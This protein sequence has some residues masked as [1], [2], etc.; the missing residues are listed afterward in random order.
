VAVD[1]RSHGRSEKTELGHTIQQYADDVRLFSEQPDINDVVLVGWSMG[2]VVSC[3]D[4]Y[5][6]GADRIRALVG[7]DM[8]PSPSPTDDRQ[9]GDN[10]HHE[11]IDSR[12]DASSVSVTTVLTD[13]E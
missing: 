10:R 11:L 1:F 2:A 5:Q 13:T 8:E 6:F 4:I 7:I 3:E 12:A 9:A